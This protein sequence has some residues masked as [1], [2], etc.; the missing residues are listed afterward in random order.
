MKENNYTIVDNNLY[1]D[2]N[3]LYDVIDYTLEH[4]KVNNA[5]FSIVFVGDEEIHDINK[6]YRQVDRITDVISFA[7][8]DNEDLMYNGIRMLGDIYIC[9]PQMKRQAKDF[10]HSEKRE[11]SF[12]ATH[13]LLHLLGYDHM[14]EEDEK[15]MFSLQE[16]ILNDK[17]IKRWNKKTWFWKI[18]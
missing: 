16:L 17:D 11:L 7:F 4:E 9:I 8:E 10:G 6:K 1:N 3:Y 12:L 14:K 15:V 18:F 13:G 2:Y 5:I